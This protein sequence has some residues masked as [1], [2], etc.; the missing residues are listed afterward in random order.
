YPKVFSPRMRSCVVKSKFVRAGKDSARHIGAHL[1]YIQDRELGEQER[2]REFF[3]RSHDKIEREDVQQHLLDHR[4]QRVAMHKMILSP[5]DNSIDIQE[6]TRESMDALED[7]LGHRLDWFAVIHENTE[8]HHAHVVIA[9][10]VPDRQLDFDR[11][12]HDERES[13]RGL[14]DVYLDR[15]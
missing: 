11:T 1:K 14:G 5:G 3:D 15:W 13:A 9:G 7:R 6:Y 8:H 4:G 10:Q 12:E 2:K